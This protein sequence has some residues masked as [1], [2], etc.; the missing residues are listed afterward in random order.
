M[1]Y[2]ESIQKVS[3]LKLQGL[4]MANI[5][6]AMGISRQRV[7]Q[8]ITAQEKRNHLASHWT[9][10]MT[11]RC[12]TIVAK[13]NLQSKEQVA[14]AIQSTLIIP[15]M[16]PNFGLQSY[17]DLCAWANVTAPANLNYPRRCPHCNEILDK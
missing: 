3:A 9:H 15:N 1:K 2:E 5:G 13:L 10:G 11:A 7:H 12:K 4:S 14:H 17:Y 16:I 8:I 6:K